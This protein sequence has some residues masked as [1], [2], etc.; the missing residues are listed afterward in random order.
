MRFRTIS[1][2]ATLAIALVACAPAASSNS[3]QPS[4]EGSAVASA[5]S[6]G[7][8]LPSL[9]EGAV[10]DLEVWIPDTVAGV[11]MEKV[12]MRGDDSLL[13]FDADV[14]GTLLQ[15]L[16]VSESDVSL[17]V[18]IG[19]SASA[20]ISARMFVFRA[21]GVN[22]D[23]LTVAFKKA[24]DSSRNTPLVWTATT[25]DGKQIET[26]ADGPA[27]NY[28]YIKE[29]VLVFLVPSNADVAAEIVSGLP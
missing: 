18:G 4:S 5:A 24:T 26:A 7:G 20:N 2:L 23:R 27:T 12:S 10:A 8:V 11:P 22:S 25:M 6:Q 28:L 15:D 19:Y 29:D 14:M 1:A 16:G 21:A 3:G 17:A 9:T 13:E